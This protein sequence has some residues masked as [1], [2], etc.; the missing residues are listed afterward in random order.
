VHLVVFIVRNY[1]DARSTELQMVSMYIVTQLCT[2]R[3]T[4]QV[5]NFKRSSAGE[6]RVRKSYVSFV[7]FYNKYFGMTMT[8]KGRNILHT[9]VYTYLY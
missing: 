8:F 5:S 6:M 3:C 4:E 2:N 7:M 1:H 9:T